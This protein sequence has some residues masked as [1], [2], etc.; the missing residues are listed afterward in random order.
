[1]IR[2]CTKYLGYFCKACGEGGREW[3]DAR[4]LKKHYMDRKAHSATELLAAG[5]GLWV[6][7]EV[8]T[9]DKAEMREWLEERG[10]IEEEGTRSSD[11][12]DFVLT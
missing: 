12:D 1:M 2:L 6:Y 3:T 11:D 7:D 8:S 10:A 5:V 9:L 4:A